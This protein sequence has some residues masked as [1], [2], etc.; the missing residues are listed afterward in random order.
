MHLK[1]PESVA[2]RLVRIGTG[3]TP[4]VLV[5]ASQCGLKMIYDH[6]AARLRCTEN[7]LSP[8]TLGAERGARA[9][10]ASADVDAAVPLVP[11]HPNSMGPYLTNDLTRLDALAQATLQDPAASDTTMAA[12]DGPPANRETHAVNV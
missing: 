9:A 4:V 1:L 2:R 11:A 12:G 6:D 5:G 8:R 7:T 3:P 10:S